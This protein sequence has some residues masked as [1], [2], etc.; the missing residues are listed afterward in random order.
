M[1]FLA[2]R[3]YL[4]AKDAFYLLVGMLLYKKRK[5]EKKKEHVRATPNQEMGRNCVKKKRQNG[6]WISQKALRVLLPPQWG[7]YLG[8][9]DWSF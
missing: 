7:L 2:P 3:R 5:K 1:S 9:V 6:G 8:E 4:A